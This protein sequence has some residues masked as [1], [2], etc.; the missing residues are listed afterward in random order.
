MLE[1]RRRKISV[2]LPLDEVHGHGGRHP[3]V[4]QQ[5]AAEHALASHPASSLAGAEARGVCGHS[6]LVAHEPAGGGGAE[7]AA[8][9]AAGVSVGH[10]QRR[11]RHLRLAA[12]QPGLRDLL[13]H[14]EHLA[15]LSLVTLLASLVAVVVTVVVTFVVAIVLPAAVL[16]FPGSC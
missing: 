8:R 12:E 1:N 14:V 7:E 3:L 16:L 4:A 9:L 13:S 5:A 11:A 2:F 10:V 15:Q 6:P